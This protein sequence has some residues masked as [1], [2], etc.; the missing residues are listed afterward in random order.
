MDESELMNQ[1]INQYQQLIASYTGKL[2]REHFGKGP[3]S[4]V[5]S[6][7]SNYITVYIRNF[8]TP[9]ERVLLEQNHEMIIHQMRETLMQSM[10]PEFASYIEIVTGVKPHEFY[11]DW[12]MDNK[13]GMLVAICPEPIPGGQDVN[14][15]YE[16]KAEIENEIVRIS[17]QAQ[18]A[19]DELISFEINPRKLIIIRNGILVRI[20]K[21]L[22]R[23]G[24]NELLKSVKR[25]M[26]KGYLHNNSSFESI[27]NKRV[28]DCFVDW[29][30]NS[31]RS[32]IL[33]VMK[34]K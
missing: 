2:I 11:Y 4:A 27:L 28:V 29:N 25:K 21:E 32:V 6:I 5:V 19:P 24:H 23:L 18:K 9:S 30:F 33:L 12:S 16:G 31:D 3:E 22:I 13:S 20:E 15:A 17:Q 10:I 1:T 26:E 7:G 14:D 8:L 34:A